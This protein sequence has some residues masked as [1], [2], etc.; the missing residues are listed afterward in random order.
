MTEPNK[1]PVPEPLPLSDAVFEDI[2]NGGAWTPDLWRSFAA[3]VR[4]LQ[5]KA[6]TLRE[7]LEDRGHDPTCRRYSSECDCSLAP[8]LSSTAGAERRDH[9]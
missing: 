2:L 7:V 4:A 9:R 5:A 3:A 8:I 1:A 6:A